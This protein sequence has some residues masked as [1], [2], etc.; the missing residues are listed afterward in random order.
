LEQQS[1]EF[2]EKVRTMGEL[3]SEPSRIV[4]GE[5]LNYFHKS[6]LKEKREYDPAML[7]IGDLMITL[8][9]GH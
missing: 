8:L 7:V 4:A 2:I 6:I 9:T 1:K 3:E 5:T